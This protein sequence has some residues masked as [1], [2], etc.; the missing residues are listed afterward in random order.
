M[1]RIVAC[2]GVV[3]LGSMSSALWAQAGSGRAAAAGVEQRAVG[4][5][6]LV[7]RHLGVDRYTLQTFDV[8]FDIGDPWSFDVV[9]GGIA[10]SVAMHPHSMRSDWFEVIVVGADG[11]HQRVEPPPIRTMKG[12]VIGLPG[13]SVRG[14]LV[15][16]GVEC[17][18]TFPDGSTWGVQPLSQ[19][20]AGAQRGVHVVYDNAHVVEPGGLCGGAIE[21]PGL[22]ERAVSGG[23][24]LR[25]VANRICEIAIDADVEYYAL[26]GSNVANTVNDI[27]SL[28][29]GVEGIYEINTGVTFEVTTIVVRTAEPDPYSSNS[30]GTL[31]GQ[32][33]SEWGSSVYNPVR[34][35]LVHMMTGKDMGG[36]LGIAYLNGV[37]ATSTRY[38]VSR[39]RWSTNTN[40][41]RAV[42]AHEIGHNFSAGHCNESAPC[43]ANPISQC[44]IMCSAIQGC[45]ST[46]TSFST[47]EANVIAAYADSRTCLTLEPAPF[48]APFSDTFPS[49]TLDTS[50]W[51][52]NRGATVSN[53]GVGEPSAPNSLQ[54]N[55]SGSGTYATDEIRSHFILMQSVSSPIL[56]YHAQ[57]RGVPNG[58]QLI[59]EVWTNQL[60]WVV[61]NTITSNGVDDNS[62][63]EYTHAL[64]GAE[65]HNEFRV[66]FRV[67]GSTSTSHNWFVDDLYVGS[68]TGSTTGSCCIGA[69]CTV[70]TQANCAGTW[71]L[72]GNCSPNLCTVATG[73]C[74]VDGDCT[75]TTQAG[76][77]GTWTENGSCSPNNCPQPTGACCF[78]TTCLALTNVQC[79][80]SNGTFLGSAVVCGSPN[81]C[82]ALGG[83]CCL[84]DGSCLLTTESVCEDEDGEFRGIGTTCA[85]AQCNPTGACCDPISNTC[86]LVT[87]SACL[88]AGGLFQ[89]ADTTCDVGTCAPPTG[90]CCLGAICTVLTS[91]E[92]DLSG[93]AFRGVGT[94]CNEPG[95]ST[96]PCCFADFDQNG[97]VEVPDLFAYLSAWFANSPSANINGDALEVSDIFSYLAAWFAGC[98]D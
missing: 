50:K 55:A 14:A 56:R 91:A 92:C 36:V 96:A 93:G 46:I 6:E 48:A 88:S 61:K 35:D 62:Y 90:A 64:S 37:C 94:G 7:R 70:T 63:T 49:T 77:S 5:P 83:A 95:I 42:I 15:D 34:K 73:S 72:A 44:Q 53:A 51:V 97:V 80:A 21:V 39:A 76:C 65:L 25:G 26:N 30:P 43:N 89:G 31:L 8:P 60:R 40:R 78:G 87:Q 74:C 23:M 11:V 84:L 68:A 27:E 57:K 3:A 41:R 29:N 47:C 28:M 79:V 9:M 12:E 17:V 71:T 1:L 52:Y 98:G 82:N 20:Q 2:I 67:V 18:V 10:Y 33:A 85:Q 66:Q 69:N 32:V 75:I 86:T 13:S 4:I 81:P 45:S 38:G 59:V 58:G 16:G 24:V 54:L 19:V 22:V